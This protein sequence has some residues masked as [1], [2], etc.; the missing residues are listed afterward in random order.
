D[1]FCASCHVHP[2]STQSWKKSTHYDNQRGIVVHCVECHLPPPGDLYYLTEKAIT[3]ARDVYGK[4]FKDIDQINW[5]KKSQLEYA[6]GHVYKSSCLECHENLFPKGLSEEG[7]EGHLHYSENPNTVR[8]INCHLHVGHYDP[9]AV[10]AQNVGFGMQAE[11]EIET[12]N[13]AAEV[14]SFADYTEYI[15]GTAVSFDMQAIP[16]GTFTMGSPEDEPFRDED[17]GP[18]VEVKLDSFYIAR[19]ETTWDAFLAFLSETMSEGRPDNYGRIPPEEMV[20]GISGPTPPYGNVDQ[21]WGR[22]DRPA[23]T[24]TH[25]AARVYCYWLSQKT[26]KKYRLPTEAEWEY[27]ARAETQGAYFFEGSPKDY[28]PQTGLFSSLFGPDTSVINTYVIYEMNSNARTQPPEEVNPN[29][30]GLKN[31]LGNVAEF[32]SDYYDPDIYETYDEQVENPQGPQSGEEFV[33]RGGSFRDEAP[34]VRSAEREHTQTEKWME[35]DP[36]M[37]QSVWWYSDANHIGFRV[38]CEYKEN[39]NNN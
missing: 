6:K 28:A 19:V 8:C 23:I 1:D 10:H 35:T 31:T 36:Q 38:V 33:I 32:C 20:D 24:M 21:G 27:A 16:G 29:P 2:H 22:G 37:P 11:E 30:F 5:E 12:Y 3:G 14:D 9:D 15:P 4:L 34:E 17:E 7:K 25:Y 26:G 18:Q 39:E 13:E